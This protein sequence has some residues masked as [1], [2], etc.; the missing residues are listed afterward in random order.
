MVRKLSRGP[1][2]PKGQVNH[3]TQSIGVALGEID[4][5]L[6]YAIYFISK[7]L[8]KAELNHTMTEMEL[9]VVVDSLNKFRHYI[10]CYQ[11]FV[12]TDHAEIKYYE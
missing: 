1:G 6:P 4:E 10:T 5:K 7:N 12:H 3:C 2:H 8:S 9:L 11:T